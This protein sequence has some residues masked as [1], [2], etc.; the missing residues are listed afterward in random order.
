M[1]IILNSVY[2]LICLSS[3]SL[4]VWFT[5]KCSHSATICII[6]MFLLVGYLQKNLIL[7]C[8][9]LRDGAGPAYSHWECT[10]ALKCLLSPRTQTG[11]SLGVISHSVIILSRNMGFWAEVQIDFWAKEKKKTYWNMSLVLILQKSPEPIY[12]MQIGLHK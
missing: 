1:N 9:I 12:S 11:E 3:Y 7:I 6:C 2:S 5:L 4:A 10:S 8:V